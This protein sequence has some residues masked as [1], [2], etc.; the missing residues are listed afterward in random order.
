L[1]KC[2]VFGNN[3]GGQVSTSAVLLND[4]NSAM[5]NGP[6]KMTVINSSTM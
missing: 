4:P 2:H 1:S 5:M 6:R 3:V